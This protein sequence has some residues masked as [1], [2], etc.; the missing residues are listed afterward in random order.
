MKSFEELQAELGPL[1]EM[2][3]PGGQGDHV[4][5]VL[6]SFG[7]GKSMLAHF[8]AQ[9]P[10][11]E[12]RY[13][14]TLPVLHRIPNCRIIYLCTESPSEEVL[15]YYTSLIPK[16]HRAGV[17]ARF[18]NIAVPDDS[19]R[20]VA[21]K[22]IDRPE[23]LETLRKALAG[24]PAFIEPWNVTHHEVEVA[25][26]L[27]VPINGTPP[28]LW[29]LGFKSAGRRIFRE[30]GV[31]VAEGRED[32]RSV[33]DVLAAIAAIQAE[34]PQAPGVV[35]KLD[36]GTSGEGNVVIRFDEVSS[37]SPTALRQQIEALPEWYL[38]DLEGGGVVEEL[39]AGSAFASPSAQADITPFGHVHVV[40]T[41]EQVLGGKDG[42]IYQGCRF[43]AD[44]AYAPLLADYIDAIGRKLAAKGVLGRIS[45]DFAAAR[46][47]T[48]T[49]RVFALE[50][51]LRKGGTTHP[52][53]LLRNLAPG[54]YDPKQG[55]WLARDRTPRFY[56]ATDNLIDARWLNLPPASVIGAIR[57]AGLEFDYE[58]G[59][60]IVVH[61]LSCLAVD[62]RFGLTAIGNTPDHASELYDAVAPLVT[63]AA[64][65]TARPS[66]A[67]S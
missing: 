61:M 38:K 32:V 44:P 39:I 51:N 15:S 1:W 40:S 60:G 19:H 50:L 20:S 46:D 34:R 21:D 49:W 54:H 3:R 2:N 23:M 45:V 17:R 13:L 10:A 55:L 29:Q 65:A 11:L 18:V 31:P 30:A 63:K 14:T 62:G 33:A 28:E 41:H 56:A 5:I 26:R 47:E 53:A 27:Q 36:N 43:P 37:T 67:S 64:E 35:V 57:E 9:L 25:R 7:L 16:E 24:L 52:F 58:R 59:S 4:L 42:Q 8:A 6:P 48:G 66:P 22:L 12:H